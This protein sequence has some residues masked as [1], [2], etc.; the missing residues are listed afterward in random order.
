MGV[1]YVVSV[2]EGAGKTAICAGLGRS[3]M[4]EGRKVGYL[5]PPEETGADGDIAFMKQA[6]GLSDAVNAPDMPQGRDVVLVEARL[7]PSAAATLSQQ[8]YGAV[9]EMKGKAIA[10]EAYSGQPLKYLD[11]YQGF[12]ESLL[13]VVLNKVPESRLKRAREAAAAQLGPQAVATAAH[14]HKEC[15]LPLGKIAQGIAHKYS[16]HIL[17]FQIRLIYGIHGGFS[18]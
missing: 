13:G 14:L 10:V 8:T 4:N 15:G 16:L 5:R 6:L 11:A 7:G 18:K 2:E 3:L 17:R 9:R 1:L 12:G